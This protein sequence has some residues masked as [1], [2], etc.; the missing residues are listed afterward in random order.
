MQHDSPQFRL[1]FA[2]ATI[3]AIAAFNSHQ[4]RAQGDPP[5]KLDLGTAVSRALE[6]D[7]QIRGSQI[8]TRIAQARIDE[9]KTG[10]LPT[11]QFNQNVTHSNNPVFVF[12]SLLEQGRFRASNF[13]LE[14]LNHP[15]GLTNFRTSVGV[16][17]PLF[18][19]F[20][21]RSR[22]N[23]A[24][25]DHQRAELRIDMAS[26]R[27]RFDVIRTFYGSILADELLRATEAAVLSAKANSRKTNDYVEVGLVTI[28]DALVANVELAS[29]EQ[30]KLESQSVALTTRAALNI[31]IGSKPETV[32]DLIGNL[33]EKHFPVE[34]QA[35]LVS[36]ALQNRPE[37]R[38]A[39]LA[40][41]D[42]RERSRSVKNQKLP[43]LD[44]FGDY[45][46]SS[47]YITN[48][49]SDYTVG[50]SLSFTIFDPGRKSRVEQATLAEAA[51]T[52]EKD[53]LSNQITLEV[54]T[55]YQN[56]NTSRSKI[57]VSVKSVTQAEEAL[58]I[59]QDRYTSTLSTFDGVLRAEAALL[60]AKHE[61][62]KAKYEYYISFASIL[63]TTGRLTDVRLFY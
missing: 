31:A 2:L 9:A 41:E 39:L 15:D 19:Q 40:E 43:R 46:Y 11:V 6:N 36:I 17:A 51:T 53:R 54:I 23:R 50:L 56:F 1:L 14:S 62:L 3:V 20:Q 34:G 27:L 38:Q 47:P 25:L 26:Q 18:D 42:S 24:D 57:Q 45:G 29:V 21:T 13:A 61:L 16:R 60:R 5:E 22:I 12:G 59:I 37:Y 58:R 63:L 7:P 10:W 49:S 8:E 52:S 33:Q 35:E 28:S 44:A 30:Q 55:A 48:G 4:L 32:H